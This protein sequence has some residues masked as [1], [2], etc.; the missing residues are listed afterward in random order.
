MGIEDDDEEKAVR[1]RARNKR[2][3]HTVV[4]LP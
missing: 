1:E 2:L 4:T 3:F